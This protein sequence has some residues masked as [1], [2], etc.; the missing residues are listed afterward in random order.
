MLVSDLDLSLVGLQ[1]LVGAPVGSA[2][3]T[4]IDACHLTLDC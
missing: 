1:D 4:L 3:F 2:L